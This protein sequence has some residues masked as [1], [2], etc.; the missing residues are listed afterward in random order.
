MYV[1]SIYEVPPI[2]ASA[3]SALCWLCNVAF[4]GP[5]KPFPATSSLQ[6]IYVKAICPAFSAIFVSRHCL[7]DSPSNIAEHVWTL[8]SDCGGWDLTIQARLRASNTPALWLPYLSPVTRKPSFFSFVADEDL[9][10]RNVLLLTSFS[11]YANCSDTPEKCLRTT[12]WLLG[13]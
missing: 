6:P 5:L 1:Y 13:T 12:S 10:G 3:I 9:R 8:N 4:Y 11:R 2:T 7:L